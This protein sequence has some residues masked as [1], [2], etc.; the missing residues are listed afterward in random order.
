MS[1]PVARP[2]A[3]DLML[4]LGFFLVFDGP[5]RVLGSLRN[6]LNVNPKLHN[7]PPP[8]HNDPLKSLG[9]AISPVPFRVWRIR[10]QFGAIYC[11]TISF[12]PFVIQWPEG[13][14]GRW[15]AWS[16]LTCSKL[17][18]YPFGFPILVHFSS[19]PQKVNLLFLGLWQLRFVTR[20][21]AHGLGNFENCPWP[22]QR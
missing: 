5:H 1:I 4:L 22:V 12:L 14:D 21:D 7:F 8:N 11:A 13:L 17:T 18:F 15:D 3:G 2:R 19:W 6:A 9:V 20:W 16:F 10:H